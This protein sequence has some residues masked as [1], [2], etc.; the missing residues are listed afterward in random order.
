[1]V[2]TVPGNT[3]RDN[4]DPIE[5]TSFAQARWF[6]GKEREL[7]RIDRVGTLT[8]PGADGASV[9]LVDAV[10]GDGAFERYAL[11]LREGHECDGV[12]PLWPAL[13]RAAGVEAQRATGFLAEDLSNTVVVLD[14]PAVLKLYRRPEAGAHPE[15]EALRALTSSPYAPELLGSLDHE[16]STMLVVQE[17]VAG[18]PVGWEGLIMRLATG[19]PAAGEPAE[20]ARVTAALHGSLADALGSSRATLTHAGGRPR[21]APRLPDRGASKPVLKR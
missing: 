17:L 1:M 7:Q 14:R 20:L 13:A 5:P 6:A 11:P 12:D 2:A 15:I 10:Y 21:P 19:D 8:V 9:E 3:V 4:P 16:G 18:E